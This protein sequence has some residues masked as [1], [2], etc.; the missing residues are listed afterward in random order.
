MNTDRQRATYMTRDRILKTLSDAESESVSAAETV[1]RLGL[2]EE[3]LD[4][5]RLQNGVQKAGTATSP[6]MGRVLPKKAL[7]EATWRK[8]LS[9][10][11]P[12]SN[13]S[14]R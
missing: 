14:L 5:M 7:H 6:A 13:A 2:G 1:V 3:Y 9:K 11:S 12:P 10:L 4:L 8:L